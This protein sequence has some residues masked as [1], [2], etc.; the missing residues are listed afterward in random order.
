MPAPWPNV[1]HF[2]TNI[3][4]WPRQGPTV[5][6]R[7]PAGAGLRITDGTELRNPNGVDPAGA[8]P[9]QGLNAFWASVSVGFIPRLRDYSRCPAA[10]EGNGAR[11]IEIVLILASMGQRPRNTC[12]PQGPTLKNQTVLICLPGIFLTFS[13]RG[14]LRRNSR[15]S[16]EAY[17]RPNHRS[18]RSRRNLAHQ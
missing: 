17:G 14:R 10:R 12:V 4:K 1:W 16:Q 5:N 7:S 2:D 6:S 13:W 18:V 9:L 11:T 15:K 3:C 8:G